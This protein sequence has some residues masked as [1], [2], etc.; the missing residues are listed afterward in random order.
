MTESSWIN[1]PL[2]LYCRTR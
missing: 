2:D 1:R